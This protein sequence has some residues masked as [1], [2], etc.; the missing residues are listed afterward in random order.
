MF[1]PDVHAA[2]SARNPRRRARHV[3]DE[4]S[5]RP[6]TK[7][8]K[9]GA[10]APDT[11]DPPAHALE[12][13]PDAADAPASTNGHAKLPNGHGGRKDSSPDVRSL[14][15]ASVELRAASVDAA[16]Q[17]LAHRSRGSKRDKKSGKRET[18]L[19][20]VWQKLAC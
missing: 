20:Q 3:S 7:R 17:Q 2:P 1:S 13:L 9:R 16:G 18:G 8:R 5:V 14:R 10:L 12:P 4:T 15:S 11:F 19:L 6:S